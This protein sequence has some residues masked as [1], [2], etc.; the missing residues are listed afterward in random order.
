MLRRRRWTG[1]AA[2]SARVGR[3][4]LFLRRIAP[5]ILILAAIGAAV[6]WFVNFGAAP[7]LTREHRSAP[8]F[9]LPELQDGTRN[10]SLD[11]LRG[12]AVVL[13]FWASWCVP[14]RREARTLEAASRAFGSR[15]A[16]LGVDHQDG[17]DSA[18]A[19]IQ[20]FHI[21]YLSGYDAAGDTAP[22]FGLIGL[23]S[24][25]FVSPTGQILGHLTGPIDSQRLR[26][27]IGWLLAATRN[28]GRS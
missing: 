3:R 25:V 27:G 13:N 7:T 16:F 23:P 24:T 6:V 9:Q 15:V 11:R 20:E 18:R 2:V 4:S 14:C 19:F 17:I 8:D 22:R 1:S 28:P 10:V 12:H 21:S 26:T 5:A